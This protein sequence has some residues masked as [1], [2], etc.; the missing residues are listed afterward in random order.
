MPDA[1]LKRMQPDLL[2]L[3]R[4][5]GACPLSLDS[6]EHASERQRY[7]V[8]AVEVGF[9]META[10]MTKYQENMPSISS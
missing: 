2:L 8:H 9:C 5:E 3:E 4:F 10:Y 7:K 1:V 6:L